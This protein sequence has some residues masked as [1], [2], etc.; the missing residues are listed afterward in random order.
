M[1][2]KSQTILTDDE[3]E[4]YDR[5]IRLRELGIDGQLRLKQGKVLIIG[6]GGL[7]SPAALYL[8]AAGVGTIGIADGDNLDLTNLQ[9]QILHSTD[10]LGTPKAESAKSRIKSLNPNVKVNIYNTRVNSDNIGEIIKEYDFVIDATDNF[11]TKYL[12]NDA[13]V[14]ANKPFSHAG[15]VHFEGQVM[16]YIPGAAC[17]RCIFPD[18]PNPENAPNGKQVGILGAVAGMLGTIQATEAVKFLTGIGKL[19]TNRLL[20]IDAMTMSFNTITVSKNCNCPICR[21]K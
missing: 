4:R 9:R 15:V 6:A 14:A 1:V 12:I 3:L 11:Q 2:S 8:A 13:C 19:L 16:T 18:Q 17:Y 20:M 5:N 7:G 10:A 21:N